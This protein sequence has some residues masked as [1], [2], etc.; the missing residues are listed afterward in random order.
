MYS[1]FRFFAT[2]GSASI[3][4]FHN[5]RGNSLS[6]NKELLCSCSLLA[7]FHMKLCFLQEEPLGGWLLRH[8]SDGN[9]PTEFKFNPRSILKGEAT[10]TVS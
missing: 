7:F 10:V 2:G 5:V 4:A 8:A 1:K 3:E 6:V 9:E